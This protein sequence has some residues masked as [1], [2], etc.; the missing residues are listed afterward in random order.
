[1]FEQSVASVK[2]LAERKGIEIDVVPSASQVDVDPDRLVQTIVN[3]LG[4]AIK[5]SPKHGKILLASEE[6]D[7]YL[8][9]TVTD[10]GPRVPV[11]HPQKVFDRFE[12]VTLPT[13]QFQGG[14]GLGLAVCKAIVEEHKG[15]IG[16]R[17]EEGQGSTFWFRL[18]FTPEAGMSRPGDH[19]S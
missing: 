4:N 14:T 6:S 3:L 8:E 11:D 5:F 9:V 10:Q 15:E 1:I 12:Q 17:G 19:G 13:K 7:S 18:P 2:D 16:V